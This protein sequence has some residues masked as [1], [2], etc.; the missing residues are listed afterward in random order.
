MKTLLT[1]LM[2]AGLVHADSI[3]PVFALQQPKGLAPSYL[4]SSNVQLGLGVPLLEPTLITPYL[5]GNYLAFVTALAPLDAPMEVSLTIGG[6]TY[7]TGALIHGVDQ[8][9]NSFALPRTFYHPV[10]GVLVINFAGDNHS[11]DFQFVDPVP[12]P[13]TWLLMLSGLMLM[14]VIKLDV[15]PHLRQGL[16]YRTLQR[17]TEERKAK[18]AKECTCE[19]STPCPVHGFETV[20]D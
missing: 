11:Y 10:D 15:P 8:C 5:T 4:S 2:L 14:A 1:I 3:G 6:I 7:S 17:Q 19:V 9:V 12:E 20:W 13:G 18:E 16:V